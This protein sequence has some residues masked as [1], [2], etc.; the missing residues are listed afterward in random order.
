MTLDT[1]WLQGEDAPIR[2]LGIG[3]STRADSRSRVLLRHALRRLEAAGAGVALA[4]VRQMALPIYDDDLPL[5]A[6]PDSLR[7]ML[8]AAR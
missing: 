1:S 5:E 4:D 8:A 2:V 3:G 6:Y 7:Q